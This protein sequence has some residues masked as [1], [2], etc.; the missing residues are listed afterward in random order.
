MK[1]NL[2]SG[3]TKQKKDW[4]NLDIIG[5]KGVDVVHNLNQIPYPFRD[6]EAEEIS[7]EHILEHLP[8]II[9][10]MKE[11][12]RICKNGA[13]IWIK[14]P[15]FRH[16]NCYDEPTHAHFFTERSFSFFTRSEPN[17]YCDITGEFEL[18]ES[19]M[20]LNGKLANFLGCK[21]VC[22]LNPPY[23][24]FIHEIAVTL[25]VIK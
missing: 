7:A 2:G 23:P 19:T 1:L 4:I 13:L 10:V 3:T 11:L 8:D 5:Q 14:V 17:N 6:N 25:K 12:H 18:M 9:A 21:I 20:V 15:Y 22:L 16:Q 24:I